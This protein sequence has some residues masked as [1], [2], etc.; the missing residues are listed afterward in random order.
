[1]KRYNAS[2]NW[3]KQ[4]FHHFFPSKACHLLIAMVFK[5]FEVKHGVIDTISNSIHFE[6]EPWY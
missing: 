4:R 6:N 3:P 5:Q 1:M 2:C